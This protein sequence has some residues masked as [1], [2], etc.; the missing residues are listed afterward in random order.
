MVALL[1]SL[2]PSGPSP[3]PAIFPFS[4]ACL[5]PQNL[6]DGGTGH[7]LAGLLPCERVGVAGLDGATTLGSR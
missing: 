5:S 7:D 1:C 4:G 2:V 3:T 6:S